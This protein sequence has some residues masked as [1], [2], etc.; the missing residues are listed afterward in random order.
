MA[1]GNST[2]SLTGLPDSAAM[3][4][5]AELAGGGFG[6]ASAG[7]KQDQ[8]NHGDKANTDKCSDDQIAVAAVHI[9]LPPDALSALADRRNSDESMGDPIA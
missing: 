4:Y 5:P 7:K 6:G 8:C 3:K 9:I 1:I 2:F